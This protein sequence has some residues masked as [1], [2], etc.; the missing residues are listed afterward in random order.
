MNRG[1]QVNGLR[2]TLREEQRTMQ[3]HLKEMRQK[4]PDFMNEYEL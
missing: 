1:A 2:Q 3:R 4:W